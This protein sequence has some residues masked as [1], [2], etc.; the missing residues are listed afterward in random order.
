MVPADLS[1]AADAVESIA[2]ALSKLSLEV[3]VLINNAGLDSAGPL[4]SK[5]EVGGQRTS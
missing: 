2:A 1:N 5:D 4:I 3:H